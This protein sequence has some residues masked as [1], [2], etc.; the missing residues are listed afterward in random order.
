MNMH[1]YIARLSYAGIIG[2]AAF[3][4]LSGS[5]HAGIATTKHNLAFDS[6]NDI[7]ADTNPEICIFCHTPHSASVGVGTLPLW[8]RA[9]STETYGVYTSD[10]MDATPD[11]IGIADPDDATV[12]NLCLS[13]HD[14]TIAINSLNRVS[15]VNP[16][17]D[18]AASGKLTAGALNSN[19]SALLDTDL[20]DDHPVNFTYDTALA[21]LDGGLH[22]PV[23]AN[24][25]GLG[26]ARLF[27]GTVQCASC[28]DPH[29]SAQPA[30]LRA[31]MDG[32]GLCLE[33][34][35]K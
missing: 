2:A 34:H 22:D 31:S 4:A 25:S 9:V 12:S 14:G 3:L 16:N 28:H 17:V 32:S 10:T 18:M 27:G 19:S 7:V 35:D 30:F 11:E 8:N 1:K 20:S 21:T 33:C 24:G 5:V 26:G 29:T 6:G 23:D 13:C 15:S